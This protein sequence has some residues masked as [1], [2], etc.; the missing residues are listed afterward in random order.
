MDVYE[1][2]KPTLTLERLAASHGNIWRETQKLIDTKPP[3][4][5]A[6]IVATEGAAFRVT[7]GTFLWAMNGLWFNF[8]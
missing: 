5:T 8:V 4:Y 1:K 7:P 2:F 3:K 6:I